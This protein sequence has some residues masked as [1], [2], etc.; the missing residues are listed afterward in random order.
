MRLR[1]GEE[2]FHKGDMWWFEAGENCI[3]SNTMCCSDL[4]TLLLW[5]AVAGNRMG[6]NVGITGG[7]RRTYL[8]FL[9]KV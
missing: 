4:R 3:L 1:Y 2:C 5:H 7:K 9:K 6:E 8:M